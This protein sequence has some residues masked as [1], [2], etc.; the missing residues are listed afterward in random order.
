MIEN[1]TT[2]FKKTL[3]LLKEGIISLSSMLNKS[4]NGVV[5]F[6]IKDDESVFGVLTGKKTLADITHEIQ[7]N[8]KPLPNSLIVDP[9]IIDDK[10]IVKVSAEGDDTPYSAY[11]RYY[12]RVNDSDIQMQPDMLQRFFES[13]TE[14]Y[15]KWEEKETEYSYEDVDENLV[16]DFVRTANGKG[17][18]DYVYKSLKETL[19]KLG[20]ITKNDKLNNAGLYLFGVSKPLTIKL[21]NFPA[22][23]RSE[24]GEIKEYRGNIFECIQCAINYIQNRISYK[25]NIIGFQREDV[26]EIPTRAIREMVINSFAHAS[27]AKTG[28][29]NKYSVFKSSIRIY[30]PGPIL[31][32]IDPMSFAS[33]KVGSKIRNVLI[34]SVLFKYGYIDSFGTGFERTFDLCNQNHVLYQ[35]ENDEFGFTF[36]FLRDVNFIRDSKSQVD[37][38]RITKLD[39][40]ILSFLKVNKHLSIPELSKMTSKSTATIH[41]H[42]DSLSSRGYLYRNGS[43]KTGYWQVR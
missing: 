39:E 24:L 38:E 2:E 9:I 30:N 14:T 15:E 7:N 42:L 21:A 28:D 22:D 3:V 37:E 35:Y 33:G 27:Y 43:R 19:Q 34:S 11:G 16:I 40:E 41:R 6:G 31:K 1:D 10:T 29:S 23:Q 13:K 5:Y 32:N 8:L 18:I 17:R 36:A 4:G 25:S 20:L 12:I 26:P